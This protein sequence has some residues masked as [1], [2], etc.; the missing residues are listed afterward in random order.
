V[1]AAWVSKNII[2][3]ETEK[4]FQQALAWGV[5]HRK[6]SVQLAGN[7]HIPVEELVSYLE[8]DI[9]FELDDSK[10]KG[11]TLYYELLKQI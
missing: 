5:E 6:E 8:N 2:P 3:S 4:N 9:S 10:M 1:F 7:L 11:L